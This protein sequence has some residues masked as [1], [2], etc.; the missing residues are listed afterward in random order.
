VGK[1][2]E[3]YVIDYARCIFCGLCVDSCPRG[4][5]EMTQDYELT[6][7]GPGRINLIKDKGWLLEK[8]GGE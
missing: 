4:A 6:V 5:I 8:R 7:P 1:Y 2:A 3:Y